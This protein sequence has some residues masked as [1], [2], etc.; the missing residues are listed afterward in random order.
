MSRFFRVFALCQFLVAFVRVHSANG[1]F[2]TGALFA[3]HSALIGIIAAGMLLHDV[4]GE[5]TP[6]KRVPRNVF[7][8]SLR[9]RSFTV[10]HGH[11]RPIHHPLFVRHV[12]LYTHPSPLT[13]MLSISQRCM[14]LHA[15]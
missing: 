12:H 5:L 10:F 13:V 15:P 7:T 6:R 8:D 4:G 3:L 2:H 11:H 1:L 9:L 14:E